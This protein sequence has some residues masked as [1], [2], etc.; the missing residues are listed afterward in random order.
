MIGAPNPSN[1]G[2]RLRGSSD[3]DDSAAET[4]QRR[5]E[6]TVMTDLKMIEPGEGDHYWLLGVLATI[7][8]GGNATDGAMTIAEFA[9]PPG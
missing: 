9:A 6:R 7:K 1:W 8:V 2:L 3:H 4:G 5:K